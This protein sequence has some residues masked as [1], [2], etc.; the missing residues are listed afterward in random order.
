M[1]RLALRTLGFAAVT[2]GALL[3]LGAPAQ[4]DPGLSILSGNSFS[5][6]VQVPVTVCGNA[7]AVLGSATAQCG[8]GAAAINGAGGASGAGFHSTRIHSTRFHGTR[9]HAAVR[10]ADGEAVLTVEDDG[11]GVPEELRE[12]VFERFVRGEGDRGSS[13]GLG[14][15]IVR[16]VAAA[17]GGSAFARTR[18]G[19]GLL[20]VASL[21]RREGQLADW[22]QFAQRS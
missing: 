10:R 1:N 8:G 2:A 3:A 15:S 14:L 9:V 20:V 6:V 5:T 16:A 12:R 18:D 11:P 22:V 4:A 19:G 17:H 7:V 13:S 21:P